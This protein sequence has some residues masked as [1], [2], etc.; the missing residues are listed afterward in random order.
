[1]LIYIL[2][3]RNNYRRAK[4]LRRKEISDELNSVQ[5]RLSEANSGASKSKNSVHFVEPEDSLSCLREPSTL[6]KAT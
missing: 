1:V 2:L 6:P 3:S 4:L 5:W